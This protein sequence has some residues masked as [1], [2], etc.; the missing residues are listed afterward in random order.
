MRPATVRIRT[1]AARA[2]A[3]I[4]TPSGASRSALPDVASRAEAWIETGPRPARHALAWRRLP[5]G[6]VDRNGAQAPKWRRTPRRLRAEAWI[7]MHGM[8]PESWETASPPARRRGSKH[9][10]DSR[11][12]A[13]L[14]SPPA[15]RRGSKL[16]QG[17]QDMRWLGVA[18]RAEA[19]I[20]TA[21]KRRNG[22]E[23]LVASARRRGSKCTACPPNLG[24]LRRLPRGGVDRNTPPTPAGAQGSHRLPRGGVD[25][26]RGQRYDPMHHV[27]ASRAEAWIETTRTVTASIS[28]LVASRAEAWIETP[29]SA[30]AAASPRGASR[31]EAW[32][33]TFIKTARLPRRAVASRAEAWIETSSTA[34]P[35]A[36]TSW[37]PP[38]RRRGSKPPGPRRHRLVGQS[39][40]ARRRGSKPA[41]GLLDHH[42]A[43]SP[44]ARRRG[45]KLQLHQ[46]VAQSDPVASR[47]EAWIET[48]ARRPGRRCCRGRLPRGGV[49]RNF[50]RQQHG[51]PL[52]RRLPRGGVD[53]NG[54]VS[55]ISSVTSRSPPARRR[56]S[57]RPIHEALRRLHRSPPARRRGSKPQRARCGAGSFRVAS[58]A[59]A[60]IETR[61][62]WPGG[63]SMRSPPARRRGSKPE[64][65]NADPG[66]RRRLPRGGV[67]R[68]IDQ[69]TGHQAVNWSPPARRRR[70]KHRFGGAGQGA[71]ASPPARRRGSKRRHRVALAAHLASPPARRHGSKRSFLQTAH[72]PGGSPVASRAEAW[73]ETPKRCPA[74]R[75]R[76]V[77][78]RAEVWIETRVTGDGL[79]VGDVASRTPPAWR[80][81][82][83]LPWSKPPLPH[84]KSPPAR[85]R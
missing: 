6:G 35:I 53:R 77:A 72:W 51:R 39:P 70:S 18:S 76:S 10:A 43:M 24:K 17:P 60:W 85:R 58:R 74:R 38:A 9:A 48:S 84:A 64:R 3:W 11:G 79:A 27:V 14:A 7:E 42:E 2:E 5:R 37:S 46:A 29:C 13:G 4:E 83:K 12:S 33:E 16:G 45:S 32:I 78:S 47:A 36:A 56:G 25:R 44:P 28:R 52:D 65:P 54:V 50:D 1:V 71:D 20:E 82:S 66:D 68:N 73:I 49:D 63:M 59:E 55:L 8:S 23:R 61:S 19:W 67:D 57:K 80:R 69:R 81:G 40:P 22:V 15:R 34:T 31:A 30:S 62:K 26:N 75:S 21:H 41:H